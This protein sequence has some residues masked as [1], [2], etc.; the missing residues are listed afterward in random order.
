MKADLKVDEDEGGC[1]D[2]LVGPFQEEYH[3]E[4]YSH[5]KLDCTAVVNIFA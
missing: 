1:R 2:K 4:S 5:E 3:I